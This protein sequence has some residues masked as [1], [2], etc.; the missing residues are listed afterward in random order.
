MVYI[1]L[2]EGYANMIK[3]MKY[4]RDTLKKGW[5]NVA[6]RNAEAA[7]KSLL[8]CFLTLIALPLDK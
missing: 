8:T 6:R 4:G 2:G 5:N 1:S 3:N 7:K